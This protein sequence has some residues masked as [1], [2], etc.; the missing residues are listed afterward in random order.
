MKAFF[1]TLFG[2][3]VNLSFV[4]L[5]V[6]LE[7]VLVNLGYAAEAGVITPLVILMGVS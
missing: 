5:V 4:A 6:G 2:D 7:A 1:K 3:W